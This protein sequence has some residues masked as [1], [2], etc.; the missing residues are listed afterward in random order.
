MQNQAARDSAIYQTSALFGASDKLDPVANFAAF[1][2]AT[3]IRFLTSSAQ[4][5]ADAMGR[6][7]AA[8]IIVTTIA[9][10]I[11]Y[12]NWYTQGEEYQ[13]NQQQI[14]ELQQQTATLKQ[15]AAALQAENQRLKSE[16]DKVQAEQAGLAAQNDALNKAI[17]G[18]KAT[19]KMPE[20]KLPYPPK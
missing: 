15:Q 10:G 12:W 9:G 3:A 13:K 7:I 14:T 18:Y 1:I 4:S 20:L 17:A 8:V 19:G 11:F 16:L 6:V 2:L 5:Y